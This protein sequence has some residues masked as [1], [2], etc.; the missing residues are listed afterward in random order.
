VGAGSAFVPSR[1]TTSVPPPTKGVTAAP[2]PAQT[3]PAGA[4]FAHLDDLPPDEP[5]GRSTGD[6]LAQKYRSGGGGSYTTGRYRERPKVPRGV[7]LPERPAVAT[8]LY[9]HT[10][11]E[12]YHRS[13]GRYGTLQQLKEAGVLALDVPLEAAGFKRMRYAFR[14]AV[15]SDGYRAEAIPLA[16]VGRAFVVDDSG[17]VQLPD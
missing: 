14:L 5:D 13:H 16:P 12:T 11:E 15:E 8:L 10:V 3:E 1:P 6:A 4:D 17:K 2:P 7:T 9:L